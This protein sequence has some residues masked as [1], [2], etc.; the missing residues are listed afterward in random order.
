MSTYRCLLK[1]PKVLTYQDE[2]QIEIIEQTLFLSAMK[3]LFLILFFM[4]CLFGSSNMFFSCV[5]FRQMLN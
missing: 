5:I 2:K 1:I 3:I 4:L